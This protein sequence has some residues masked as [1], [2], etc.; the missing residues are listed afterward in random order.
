[1]R[2]PFFCDVL[3]K[4]TTCGITYNELDYPVWTCRPGHQRTSIIPGA[5]MSGVVATLGLGRPGSPW[6]RKCSG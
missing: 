2:S 1:M 4:V 3:V 6:A 5:E